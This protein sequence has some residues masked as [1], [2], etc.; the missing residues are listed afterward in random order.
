MP[1]DRANYPADW[2]DFSQ[3][4]RFVRAAGQCE[5]RG[6]CGLHPATT[7]RRRCI[8]K[9]GAW[10]RHAK[11]RVVL[12]TAHLCACRPL[13]A[14]RCHVKA[15]CQ[16]CHLRVDRDLHAANAA[17]TRARTRPGQLSLLEGEGSHAE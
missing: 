4:I 10:A 5:C 15:M 6:E 1:A 3:A 8:E 2:E 11:G 14:R 9:H 7:G 12:T 17:R 16:R 13:C